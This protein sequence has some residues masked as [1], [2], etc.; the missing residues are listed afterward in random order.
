[1]FMSEKRVSPP[2]GGTSIARRMEP[3]EGISRQVTS[4]CQAFS[5]PRLFS[6]WV[7]ASTSG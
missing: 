3:S 4:L 5:R 2:T 7:I 1:M 6:L